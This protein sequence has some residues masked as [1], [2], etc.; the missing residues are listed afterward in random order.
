MEKTNQEINHSLTSEIIKKT[1]PLVLLFLV[2][3]GGGIVAVF[4]QKSKPEKT[5]EKNIKPVVK[6]VEQKQPQL[7]PY[8]LFVEGNKVKLKFHSNNSSMEFSNLSNEQKVCL[9]NGGGIGCVLPGYVAQTKSTEEEIKSTSVTKNK[10]QT[11]QIPEIEASANTIDNVML[12]SGVG[13]GL[14]F[15]DNIRKK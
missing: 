13:L 5:I 15:I 2:L 9:A 11:F 10:K 3:G 12:I 6:K 1:L 7:P 14:L 4:S 8:T